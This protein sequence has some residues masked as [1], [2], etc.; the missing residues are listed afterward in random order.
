MNLAGGGQLLSIYLTFWFCTWGRAV[1]RFPLR[2]V[3]TWWCLP[4]S[5]CDQDSNNIQW[6][7]FSFSL[8]VPGR[9]KKCRGKKVST[10][11][12]WLYKL[13]WRCAGTVQCQY[14]GDLLS[15]CLVYYLIFWSAGGKNVIVTVLLLCREM[16]APLCPLQQDLSFQM[17]L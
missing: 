5:T 6:Y 9:E 1:G 2:L 12:L 7:F 4:G 8:A 14:K 11:V 10:T 17:L 13:F 16:R 3:M 15:F